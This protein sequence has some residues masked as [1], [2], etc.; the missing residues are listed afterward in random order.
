MSFIIALRPFIFG[1]DAT[2]KTG[3]QE[4]SLK[5]KR[6]LRISHRFQFIVKILK[7]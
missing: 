4:N 1:H 6:N 2:I 3:T 5:N 7:Q